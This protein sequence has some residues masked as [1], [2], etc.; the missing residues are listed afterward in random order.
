MVIDTSAIFAIL[1][2]EAERPN[3]NRKI[4]DDGVRLISSGTLLEASIVIGRRYGAGGL[5][6]LSRFL[7]I[8]LFETVAFDAL[9]AQ[10]AEKAYRQYGK[11]NHPAALNFGD[12]FSYALAKYRAE[13]LLYKGNDFALTDIQAVV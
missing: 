3:F 11:G 7:H 12:C 8:G 2:D 9:Q 6:D 4:Q 5:S 1:S 10:I 13:P